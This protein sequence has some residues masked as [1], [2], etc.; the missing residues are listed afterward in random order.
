M[1]ISASDD[2]PGQRR[3]RSPAA[4]ETPAH[5]GRRQVIFLSRPLGGGDGGGKNVLGLVALIAASAL[6][7]WVPGALGLAGTLAGTLITAGITVG[8][9]LLINA[10]VAPKAGGQADA[11][12]PQDSAPQAFSLSAAG[13]SARALQTIPVSYGRLRKYCDFATLPWSEFV[14]DEQYLNV[15]LCEGGGKYQH[16]QVLIDDTILWTSAGGFNPDFDC[17]VAFYDPGQTVTLFPANVTTAVEVSGQQLPPG[18]GSNPVNDLPPPTPGPWIGGFIANGPGTIADTLALDFAFPAGCFVVNRDGDYFGRPV[19]VEA[20]YREVNDA[21]AAIGDWSQLF[22][23]VPAYN[24]RKPQKFSQKVGVP[25]GRY[26]VRAR[27]YGAEAADFDAKINGASGSDGLIWLQLR[28]YLQGNS[29]F[30][31]EFT[32]AI[33]IRAT[34]SPRVGAQVLGDLNPHFAGLERQCFVDQPTRNPLWAFS[35]RCDQHRL[36]RQA[37]GEQDRLRHPREHGDGRGRSRR[38][39][40]LRIPFARSGSQCLRHHS[41]IDPRASSLVRRPAVG[42]AR[43]GADHPATP[44]Y[45]S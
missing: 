42:R 40:R 11:G 35:G 33:R 29:S 36:W 16:E 19:R 21:G 31:N 32:V 2:L 12:T 9:S 41:Q 37:T 8:A 45:G 26:E 24:T 5:Q 44:A 27:R 15:L 10:L 30:A 34:Q 23:T 39:V 3:L 6:A 13:N 17:V 20:E 28:A 43:R 1:G 4:L 38:H 22:F 18:S 25:P 14:G 7:L